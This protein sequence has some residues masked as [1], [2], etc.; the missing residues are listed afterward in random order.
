MLA[1]EQCYIIY[2]TPDVRTCFALLFVW[3][4]LLLSSF[5][6]HHSLIH[7]LVSDEK[8]GRKKQARSNKQGKATQHTQ[9]SHLYMYTYMHSEYIHSNQWMEWDTMVALYLMVE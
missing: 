4:C 6:P 8:E 9:G 5:H 2:I 7:V 3:P 1:R